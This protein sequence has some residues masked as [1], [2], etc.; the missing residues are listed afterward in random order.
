LAEVG[1]SSR[2]KLGLGASG[3]T[4]ITTRDGIDPITAQSYER[5]VFAFKVE[6]D[7]RNLKTDCNSRVVVVAFV[8]RLQVRRI[9]ERGGN[10]YG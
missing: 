8:L 2:C 5:P 3:M 1:I 6:R 10:D 4:I 9:N 7:R